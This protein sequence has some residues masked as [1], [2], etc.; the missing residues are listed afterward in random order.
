ML[1]LLVFEKIAKKNGVK[2]ISRDALEEAREMI[3]ELAMDMCDKAVSLSRH[4]NRRTVK[5]EDI[6][7]IS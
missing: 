4:A 6:K 7:F 1:S 3:E 5:E 2:R